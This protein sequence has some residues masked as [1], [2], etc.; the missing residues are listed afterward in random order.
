MSHPIE[1]GVV[2]NWEDMEKIYRYIFDKLGVNSK[3]HAVLLTEPVLNPISNRIMMA[4]MMFDN[5]GVPAV[6]FQNQ[7]V[8]S[9][10]A[11]GIT[12]GVVVDCGD[13]VTTTS[14]IY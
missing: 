14:A 4:K 9:L 13:G 8:L 6:Y 3:E 10:Y 2:Q 12:T 7:S 11:R 1:H 5:F